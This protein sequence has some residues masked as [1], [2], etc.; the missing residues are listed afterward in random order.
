M[1]HRF[2][3]LAARQSASPCD[4][5]I[6]LLGG[7]TRID[8]AVSAEAG[9]DQLRDNWDQGYERVGQSAKEEEGRVGHAGGRPVARWTLGART[10]LECTFDS[11]SAALAIYERSSKRFGHPMGYTSCSQ[12]S[13]HPRLERLHQGRRSHGSR[14][15]VGATE[16]LLGGGGDAEDWNRTGGVVGLVGLDMNAA[17]WGGV[18]IGADEDE[19]QVER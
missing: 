16:V 2:T 13:Q 12:D 11:P 18:Q 6:S 8:S 10:F 14:G 1:A 17:D 5:G 9:A 15:Q 19:V 7:G 3:S 4:R